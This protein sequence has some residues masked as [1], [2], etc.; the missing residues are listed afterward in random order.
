MARV[1]RLSRGN[2]LPHSLQNLAGAEYS[3]PHCGQD[4][5]VGGSNKAKRLS[6]TEAQPNTISTYRP[7][8][9]D[10][11]V[12]ADGKDSTGGDP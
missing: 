10:P 2:G 12:A 6:F 1:S 7:F 3:V 4:K 8:Q 5:E 9:M 11:H